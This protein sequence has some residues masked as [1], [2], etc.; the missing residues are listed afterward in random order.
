MP[1]SI[2]SGQ[3][4]PHEACRRRVTLGSDG[5]GVNGEDALDAEPAAPADGLPPDA[6][7]DGH[8][9]ANLLTIGPS[10]SQ[11]PDSIDQ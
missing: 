11:A 2:Q 8:V 4:G 7:G 3:Y 1:G 9:P 5:G 6:P 10:V